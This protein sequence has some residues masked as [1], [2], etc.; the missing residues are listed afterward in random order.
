MDDV[1]IVKEQEVGNGLAQEMLDADT[2][3]YSFGLAK[4]VGV[5]ASKVRVADRAGVE[6]NGCLLPPYTAS[7]YMHY[8]SLDTTLQTCMQLKA[9]TIVGLGYK[10]GGQSV[11]D[12]VKEL[13]LAPNSNVSDTFTQILKYLYFD[14]DLLSN[15]YF[16]YVKSGRRRSLYYAPAKD[17]YV[18]PKLDRYGN[19][20]PEVDAYVQISEDNRVLAEFQPYPGDG[21]T[22][23][24]VHYMI[25]FKKNAQTSL[26]YGFSDK[27][28]VF[29]L[30]R[31][32]YLADQYNINFF[33]NGGQPAWAILITGGKLSKAGYDKIKEFIENNLKGVGNAHK[34]LFI[35]LP[36]EKAQIKLAPLSKAI[37]EQFLSLSEKTQYRIAQ[38]MQ[39]HPKLLGL[40]VGGNFGGGSAGVAD[41][42]LFLETVY[43]PEARYICDVINRFIYQEFGAYAEFNLNRMNISNE[44]DLAV[45]ANLYWNMRDDAGNR[46]L[47][48]NE[49]RTGYLGLNPIDLVD[50]PRDESQDDST[51]VGITTEGELTTSDSSTLNQGDGQ[52][53]ENLDP[54]KNKH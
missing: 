5:P 54:D 52:A 31:Q 29:N 45:I 34:M 2:T 12:S 50:T 20:L 23:E 9:N 21:K 27:T 35:S 39:V 46:V 48:I 25:H 24:R 51:K 22:K 44:K 47:S 43:V 30:V 17:I 26:H 16:E 11:P 37:D 15:G 3:I 40:S 33:S 42:K 41:L 18:R 38:Y 4:S 14:I 7:R 36:N 53:M 8:A 6:S 10:F 28:S 32:S 13:F 49:I 1:K 19:V